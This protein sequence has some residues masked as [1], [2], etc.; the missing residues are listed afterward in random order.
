[1]S[2]RHKFSELEAGMKPERRERISRLAEAL[3]EKIDRI[4]SASEPPLSE[5]LLRVLAQ[6]PEGLTPRQIHEKLGLK[7]GKPGEQA[8]LEALQSLASAHRI[9]PKERKYVLA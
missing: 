2:G 5:A 8:V 1:M 6:H 4:P 7:R 3:A 9:S